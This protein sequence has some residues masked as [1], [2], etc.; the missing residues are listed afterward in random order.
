[1]SQRYFINLTYNGTNYCGW[2]VQPNGVTVQQRLQEALS[3]ILRQP[4]EVVG[5]G[6]T[7]AGVHAT[8]MVAHFDVV[9]PINDHVK[10]LRNL[11]SFLPQD[12]AIHHLTPVQPDAHARF[13]A[14]ART[15]EYWVVQH[16]SP[17][18]TQTACR[19]TQP[20]DFELMNQAAQLLFNYTDFTSF[21]KLH[22]DVKTNL[23]T[24]MRAEWQQRNDIWVFTIQ[25]NRFLRN[26]VRA[27]VGT[28]FEVG[29]HHITL[30]EFCQ[31]IEAKDRGRAGHSVPAHALYLTKVDY[32][33]E[34]YRPIE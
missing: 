14:T 8:G 19:M 31:I 18:Q 32:P 28:L 5:A 34:I 12:I 21:S 6:R 2:Q 16:K 9:Q 20:L 17:F 10:L 33:E 27:I 30:E 7:D 29:L 22:T 15:Y 11:N 4:I 3:T 25:A 1:M 24:I 13:D 23:C 26:M